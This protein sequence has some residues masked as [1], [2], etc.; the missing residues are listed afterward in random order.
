M[1][2]GWFVVAL[3]ALAVAAAAIL[4]VRPI[5]P[6]EERP[7]GAPLSSMRVGRNAIYVPDQAPAGSVAVGFAVL[8]EPGFV[9][10]RD[11]EEGP[12]RVLGASRL[13]STGETRDFAVSLDEPTSAGHYFAALYRDDGDE[14]FEADE[15]APVRDADGSAM[16]M[17]F[18][19]AEDAEP[20]AGVL[21]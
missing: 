19:V 4:I 1:S 10:I 17:R 7:A 16:M 2:K 5:A 13:L 15:D 12:G 14:R 6:R 20:P 11:D 3:A 21:P 9:V 18:L 8:A